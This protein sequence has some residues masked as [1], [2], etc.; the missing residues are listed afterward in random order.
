MGLVRFVPDIVFLLL[1]GR[2]VVD[3]QVKDHLLRIIPRSGPIP[4]DWIIREVIAGAGYLTP[5]SGVL[6]P[7]DTRKPVEER[8]VASAFLLD[9]CAAVL[10]DV[11]EGL[12][13]QGLKRRMQQVGRARGER[14]AGDHRIRA[15]A[16]PGADAYAQASRN[17]VHG[18]TGPLRPAIYIGAAALQGC[19]FGRCFPS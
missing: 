17:A 15:H 7:G 4:A 3:G 5:P 14:P 10:F 16:E 13:G 6:I 18:W 1:P 9:M 12:V 2:S 19:L 8:P 11:I